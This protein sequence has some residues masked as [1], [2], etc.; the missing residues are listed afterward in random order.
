MR[1]VI[2]VALLRTVSGA[3]TLNTCRL[4]L[5]GL[6]GFRSVFRS[7]LRPIKPSAESPPVCF[8]HGILLFR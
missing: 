8:W 3:E 1:E 5:A 2:R 7:P 4:A 6:A